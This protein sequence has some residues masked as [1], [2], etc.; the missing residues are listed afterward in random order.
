[1]IYENNIIYNT[2]ENII[3]L[4]QVKIKYKTKPNKVGPSKSI[5][6]RT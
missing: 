6:H 4:I 3:H 5:K 1:M 2:I